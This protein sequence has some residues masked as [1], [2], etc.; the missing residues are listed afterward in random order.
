MVDH[1]P[2]LAGQAWASFDG[3]PTRLLLFIC[4]GQGFDTRIFGASPGRSANF[5]DPPL[6]ISPL[7][8]DEGRKR[9]ALL[10][11]V[12]RQSGG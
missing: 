8:C 10:S 11:A 5:D 6:G 12:Y 2:D 1:R 7:L 4:R 9:W 3:G